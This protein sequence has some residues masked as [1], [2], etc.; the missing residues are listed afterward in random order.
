MKELTL[1]LPR[2]NKP[3]YLKIAEAIRTSIIEGQIQPRELLPSTRQLA[4][5]FGVHRHTIMAGLNELVAEGWIIA[6]ERKSFQVS[7]ELPTEF[8]K[9]K[10]SPVAPKIK[11]HWKIA[12]ELQS[13]PFAIDFSRQFKYNFQ[14]GLADLRLFPHTEFR[15]FLMDA[16]KRYPIKMMNYSQPEGDPTLIAAIQTYIRRMRAIVDRDVIVTHGSQEAIYMI[17]QLLLK[18]GDAVA[19]ERLGYFPAWETFR[20]AGA[21]IF[22]I[23]IDEAGLKLDSLEKLLK[24]KK[25]RLL[26]VTPLHQYPT[27]VTLNI[28]RRL[29]LY[30]LAAEYGV[31]ILED[32]YDHEF[33]YASEPLAP[34]ASHDPNGQVIYVSTFSKILF[35]AARIG[36]MAVPKVIADQLKIYKRISSRQNETLTQYALAQWIEEGGFERH[37]RRMRRVYDERRKKI[38]EYIIEYQQK[39]LKVNFKE[40]DGGMA[41]WIN[42]YKNTDALALSCQKQSVRVLPE[43][44]YSLAKTKSTHLRL[45]FANQTPQEIKA[46]IDIVF[47]ILKK[48]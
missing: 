46:G 2:N 30:Q 14:S 38:I 28:S 18:P 32:D 48:I 45:G 37:L 41:I 3:Y 27:T 10:K 29:G 6:L 36:F 7:H 35:P 15:S 44:L 20:A 13:M 4:R 47:N 39:G 12:R 42:T 1:A 43:S 23:D 26:Y 22:P 40:P 25:I 5:I 17:S 19:V 24:T 31:P 9:L 16:Y 11:F 21:K 8:F 33:H 34:L